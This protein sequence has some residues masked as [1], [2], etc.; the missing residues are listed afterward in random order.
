MT[1]MCV[2]LIFGHWLDFYQMVMPG[3]MGGQFAPYAQLS[4]FEFGIAIGYVG[5][6]VFFV[7]KAL[8]K[9]PLVQKFHPFFKESL[10]HH[11]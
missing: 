3:L 11:V 1:F 2:L 8:T 10:I 9:Q 7:G 4:W 6:I 5:M